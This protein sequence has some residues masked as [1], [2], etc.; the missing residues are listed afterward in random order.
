MDIEWITAM[1]RDWKIT[2]STAQMIFKARKEHK[3]T[4]QAEVKISKIENTELRG[5]KWIWEDTI[6]KLLSI[7]V[8]T[9]DQIKEKWLEEIKKVITNPL[10]LKTI[11]KII[12]N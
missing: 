1:V 6:K 7:G 8:E 5:I 3:E 2:A 11:E 10:A 9:E 4:K 12:N